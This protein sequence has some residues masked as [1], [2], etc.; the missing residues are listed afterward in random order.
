M[1]WKRQA[2][3]NWICESSKVIWTKSALGMGGGGDEE[4]RDAGLDDGEGG[5]IGKRFIW[6]Q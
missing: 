5:A 2:G 1:A 6:R 3:T 4:E